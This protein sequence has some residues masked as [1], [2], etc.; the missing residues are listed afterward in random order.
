MFFNL[1]AVFLHICL[2]GGVF[3]MT[4]YSIS[5][6]EVDLA[7]LPLRAHK[8]ND[9][10]KKEHYQFQV[11]KTEEVEE[12]EP[13]IYYKC[14]ICALD[15][16]AAY[17]HEHT[18]SLKHRANA[19]IARVATQRT[20]KLISA[21]PPPHAP[22]TARFCANCSTIVQ[23]NHEKTKEHRVAV[24]HDKLLW[25]LMSAY[26]GDDCND[27]DSDFS[28]TDE[29]AE[30]NASS[31]H[32]NGI[33]TW[34]E[35]NNNKEEK[36]KKYDSLS[37]ETDKKEIDKMA[38]NEVEKQ[39]NNNKPLDNKTKT[40]E[41]T[42][43]DTRKP[44]SSKSNGITNIETE[45]NKSIDTNKEPIQT[46]AKNEEISSPKP[47]DKIDYVEFVSKNNKTVKVFSD[48]YHSFT[49][50]GESISCKVCGIVFNSE[51]VDSHMF[52]LKHLNKMPSTLINEHCVRT[53]DDVFSHCIL[54][55]TMIKHT[56][57]AK[58][59][60]T[61]G[62]SQKE[63]Q[64]IT[65]NPNFQTTTSNF[66]K[67]DTVYTPI[68]HKLNSDVKNVDTVAASKSPEVK[69]KSIDWPVI[70][71]YEMT[72]QGVRC[73]ICDCLVPNNPENRKGHLVGLN[74]VKN[75][76]NKRVSLLTSLL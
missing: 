29:S 3:E 26:V 72:K 17:A 1:F 76:K 75:V 33:A 46:T 4:T 66:D 32:Y 38:D 44:E 35:V 58:H 11:N 39:N 41:V 40:I 12:L 71:P 31:R 70:Y 13:T 48:H 6:D 52:S 59:Y 25:E 15:V 28:D 74:H 63:K 47:Q 34:N 21:L 14:H 7:L 65:D 30:E 18:T 20:R 42:N 67:A 56:N 45:T 37:I 69:V 2:R 16:P 51:E 5:L 8:Y 68:T 49:R 24:M 62:H 57:L 19:R 10:L 54:C 55:N 61:V 43:I 50:K 60:L 53:I 23:R 27:E 9:F 73:V 22:Q 64:L 36:Q